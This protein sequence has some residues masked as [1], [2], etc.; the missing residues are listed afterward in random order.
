MR[1]RGHL[2]IFYDDDLQRHFVVVVVYHLRGVKVPS[3]A[4]EQF[5]L[6]LA[7]WTVSHH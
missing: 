4:V 1:Q 6:E 5:V 3:Q 7:D 2:F